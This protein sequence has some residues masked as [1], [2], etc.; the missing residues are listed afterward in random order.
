[1][2]KSS[3]KDLKHLTAVISGLGRS[4]RWPDAL[5][6]FRRSRGRGDTALSNSLIRALGEGGC[7]EQA[8]QVFAEMQRDT[9]PGPDII[10]ITSLITAC[11][12]GRRWQYAVGMV[13]NELRKGGNF[14]GP[15]LLSSLLSA[16]AACHQ[17]EQVLAGLQEMRCREW[18]PSPVALSAALAA[19]SRA[20]QWQTALELHRTHKDGGPANEAV[21]GAVVHAAGCGH[22][23]QTALLLQREML[24]LS[25]RPNTVVNN[26]LLSSLAKLGY[27]QLAMRVFEEMGPCQPDVISFNSTISACERGWMWTAALQLFARMRK[28]RVKITSV[29]CNALLSALEKGQQWSQAISF[30]DRIQRRRLHNQVSYNCAAS[31]CGKALRW[32]RALLLQGPKPDAVAVAVS[33]SACEKGLAWMLALSLLGSARS[34]GMADVASYIAAMGAA[35]KAQR[36]PHAL[37]VLQQMRQ[38]QLRWDA[39]S[40]SA[41]VKAS[42]RSLRWSL[43][44]HVL[45]TGD[46]ELQEAP[47]AAD[48]AFCA[49]VGACGGC[50]QWE[51]ALHLMAELAERGFCANEAAW[52]A[53]LDGFQRARQW[54][55]ALVAVL[56]YDTGPVGGMAAAIASERSAGPLSATSTRRLLARQLRKVL[57]NGELWPPGLRKASEASEVTPTMPGSER[58]CSV[59]VIASSEEFQ[60]GRLAVVATKHAY[61]P[62]LVR[63]MACRRFPG[64]DNSQ[65]TH[66]AW[67]RLADGLGPQS[68]TALTELGLR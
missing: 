38:S 45:R 28:D 64:T 19:C 48:M 22:Q 14:A 66:D 8:Q 65:V 20:L 40:L 27:W 21:Y 56:Q 10:S 50:G 44:L 3:R 37:L 46:A 16:C 33:I 32:R 13:A 18:T 5:R 55:R 43:A 60:E 23:W 41:A 51:L 11:E 57:L 36:W 42:G 59:A 61:W 58:M 34:S 2:G 39:A 68:K 31:A 24:S 53:A 29:S 26:S 49:A 7:W 54:Q 1:M 63:L 4:L 67:L 30:L 15:A 62:L 9:L 25:C 6:L 35:E 52:G 12:R 47:E 17:W